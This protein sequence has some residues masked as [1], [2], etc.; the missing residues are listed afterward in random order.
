M[1]PPSLKQYP[2]QFYVLIKLSCPVSLTI[3]EYTTQ[4]VEVTPFSTNGKS[5]CAT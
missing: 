5:N 2:N 1:I 4:R 3:K